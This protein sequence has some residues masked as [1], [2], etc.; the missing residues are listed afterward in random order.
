MRPFKTPILTQTLSLLVCEEDWGENRI[1]F[2]AIKVIKMRMLKTQ[3]KILMYY[4]GTCLINGSWAAGVV[5]IQ[6]VPSGDVY[7]N[8]LF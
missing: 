8:N 7:R 2:R 1:I 5:R 6:E 4:V 3:H